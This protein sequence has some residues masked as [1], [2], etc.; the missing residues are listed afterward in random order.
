MDVPRLPIVSEARRVLV[1]EVIGQ[2][3]PKPQRIIAVRGPSELTRLA[4]ATRRWV[5]AIGLLLDVYG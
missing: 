2:R 4:Y 5:P 3:A 1:P